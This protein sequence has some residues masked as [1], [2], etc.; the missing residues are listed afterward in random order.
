MK[1]IETQVTIKVLCPFAVFV[2]MYSTLSF[3]ILLS[4]IDE[5]NAEHSLTTG[6]IKVWSD[7]ILGGP[8]KYDIL[9]DR[10]LRKLQSIS[11]ALI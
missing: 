7:K 8:T 10:C 11:T 3:I 2:D 1:R 5:N 6:F 4:F 9:S